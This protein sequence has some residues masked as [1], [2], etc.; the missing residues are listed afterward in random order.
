M[1]ASRR[2]TAKS[3]FRTHRRASSPEFATT[4]FCVTLCRSCCRARRLFESSSTIKMLACDRLV[5]TAS[6]QFGYSV[7]SRD[8]GNRG[9][10]RRKP[11]VIQAGCSSGN[12]TV[13]TTP[14]HSGSS[15]LAG[16]RLKHGSRPSPCCALP[17]SDHSDLGQREAV[18]AARV[19]RGGGTGVPEV[20]IVALL[21]VGRERLVAHH[22]VDRIAGGSGNVPGDIRSGA[23][24]A[25]LVLEPF[26]CLDDAAEKPCV[27]VHPTLVRAGRRPHDAADEIA[28]VGDRKSTRLNSSHGYI[29]YAVFCL[30]KKKNQ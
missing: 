11:R 24:G 17:A 14:V 28:G 6:S 16:T 12:G 18:E 8:N 27:Q 13:C 9:R 20:N 21:Q 10:T 15:L 3:C 22:H 23:V 30:K 26:G 7:K 29:S 25:D 4:T 5:S 1:R 2:M 19:G